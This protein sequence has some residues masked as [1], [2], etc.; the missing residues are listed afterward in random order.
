SVNPR[1]LS[2]IYIS[3]KLIGDVWGNLAEDASFGMEHFK[4]SSQFKNFQLNFSY[5]I[6][7]TL[8]KQD[9]KAIGYLYEAIKSYL[10]LVVELRKLAETEAE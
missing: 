2:V 10:G 6:K 5:Y 3:Q 4:N 8:E 9:D 7:L 1:E